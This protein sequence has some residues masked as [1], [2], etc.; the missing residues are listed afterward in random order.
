MELKDSI[1]AETQKWLSET[2]FREAHIFGSLISHDGTPFLTNR[3]DIDIIAEFQKN[4]DCMERFRCLCHALSS[5]HELNLQ[6]LARLKRSAGDDPITSIVSVSPRE[7]SLGIHKGGARDFFSHNQFEC[8]STGKV[9]SIGKSVRHSSRRMESIMNALRAAQ[10]YRNTFL[11]V[12]PSGKRLAN[13][14]LGP[15]SMPKELGR[16]AAQV[17]WARETKGVE[18]Q[19]F[20]INEGQVYLLQLVGARRKEHIDIEGLFKVL[21]I[22][23]GGRGESG[24]LNPAQQLLLWEI[25]A[26]DA[27]QV[28]SPLV[29]LAPDKTLH[30]HTTKRVSSSVKQKMLQEFGNKCPFPGCEIPLGENGIAELA[31]IRDFQPNGP[32]YDPKWSQDKLFSPENL[33]VL[34]PTHHAVIDRNPDQYSVDEIMGWKASNKNEQLQFNAKNVMT[35]LRL[36]LKIADRIV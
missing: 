20:D 5:T 3:S 18:S 33:V 6:L 34:C 31:F 26:D 32:R 17:R 16:S 14:F 24:P 30:K 15:D 1:F 9:N 25:L 11:S 8:V 23:M 12:S 29:P 35:L 4:L 13:D 10:G 7:L 2:S 27:M 22:R 36:I 21:S 19:R 28:I